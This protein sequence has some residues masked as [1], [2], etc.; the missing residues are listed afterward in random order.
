MRIVLD[1]NRYADL[2][3]G[4]PEVTVRVSEANEVYLPF[5]VL[6]ELHAGFR[7]GSKRSDN[8]RRLNRFL[9]QPGIGVIYPDEKT[10]DI[11]ADFSTQLRRQGSPIPDHDIWI[12]AL[13]LQHNLTLYSRDKHF[14]HLPQIARI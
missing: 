5:V 7:N 2:D 3:R 6:A 13:A 12:A 10:V 1:T 11:Y 8:E 9:S 4:V 14:D